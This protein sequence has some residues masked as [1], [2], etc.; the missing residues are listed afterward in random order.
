VG[1]D[2]GTPVIEDYAAQMPFKFTGTL[3]KLTIELAP[4]PLS[5]KDQQEI[6]EGAKAVKTAE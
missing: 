4:Q 6:E 3:A 1:E 5:A 2:T